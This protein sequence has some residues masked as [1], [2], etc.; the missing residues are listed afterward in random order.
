MLT[1]DQIAEAA[2]ALFRAEADNRP[3]TPISVRFPD[4]D[5]D[6]A[7]RISMAVTRLKLAA[8]RTVKGHKV[9]LTSKVMQEL[10]GRASRLRADVRRL[11]RPRRRHRPARR[12]NHPL[13]EMELAFVLGDALDGGDVDAA[14]VRRATAVVRPCIEIIDNRQSGRGPR[15]LVDSIADAAG[16]GRVVLGGR[17]VG[18]DDIDIR[19]VSGGLAINGE[20]RER[21][22]PTR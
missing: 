9:G 14:A 18:L 13:V 4:A 20:V 10:R 6:D 8:G 15:P 5:I 1:Q 21:A 11:V 7:Y 16:C 22:A 17:E 3:T 19:A 12:M 2:T